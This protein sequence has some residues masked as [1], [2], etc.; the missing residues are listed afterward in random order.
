MDADRLSLANGP[1]EMTTRSNPSKAG[2]SRSAMA[3]R[4]SVIFGSASTSSVTFPA[5]SSRS[6]ASA[7]PAGTRV[8][9]ATAMSALPSSRSSCLIRPTPD[10]SSSD[11]KE[12]E[13]TSSASCGMEGAGE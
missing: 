11:R 4:T 9:S 13:Q 7:L 10:A 6:T 8:A 5:N 1:A 12:L 3:L 2:S